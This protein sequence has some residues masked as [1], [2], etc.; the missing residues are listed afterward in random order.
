MINWEYK[1]YVEPYLLLYDLIIYKSYFIIIKV[2]LNK[3]N[4]TINEKIKQNI[5]II[6]KKYLIY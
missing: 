1:K 6:Y 5:K 2:Y 3:L 4:L